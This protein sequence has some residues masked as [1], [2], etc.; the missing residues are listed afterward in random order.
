MGCSLKDKIT[1]VFKNILDKSGRKPNKIWMDKGSEFYNRSMKPWLQD[2]GTEMYSTNNKGKYVVAEIFI[3]A[4]K[5][6]IINMWLQ[7]QKCVYQ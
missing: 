6:R 7:Y 1:N 3:R 5:N 4:L 2:N